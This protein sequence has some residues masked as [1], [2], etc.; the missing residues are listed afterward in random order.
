MWNLRNLTDE[1]RGKKGK[2]Q[3]IKQTLNYREETVAE[4]EAGEGMS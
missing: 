1:H 4:G 3:S 2:R